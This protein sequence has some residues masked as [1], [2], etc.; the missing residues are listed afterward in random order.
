M[1]QLIDLCLATV[2]T[3]EDHSPTT[4]RGEVANNREEGFNPF[5]MLLHH[6]ALNGSSVHAPLTTEGTMMQQLGLQFRRLE[7]IMPV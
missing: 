1:L 3:R 7:E 2:S 4:K 5:C 6:V